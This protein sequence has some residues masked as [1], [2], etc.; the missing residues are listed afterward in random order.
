MGPMKFKVDEN[1]PVESADLLR[2]AGH[3]AVTVGDQRLSGA[4]DSAVAGVCRAEGRVLITLDVDFADIRFYPPEMS[5]G[6]IVLRAQRQDRMSVLALLRRAMALVEREP[7]A[8]RLWVID[9]TR[10]RVRGGSD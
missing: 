10:V 2:S 6:M 9:E 7:L 5:S 3:D 4:A 1:L 8:A